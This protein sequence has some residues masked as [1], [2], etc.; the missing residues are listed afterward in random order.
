[1]LFWT[2][3]LGNRSHNLYNNSAIITASLEKILSTKKLGEPLLWICIFTP[4]DLNQ[5]SFNF[6]N[7]LFSL[8]FNS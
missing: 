2:T 7:K 5:A 6:G 3:T 1:M 8:G 4:T